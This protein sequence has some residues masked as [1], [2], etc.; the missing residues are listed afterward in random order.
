[1]VA[2]SDGPNFIDGFSS[3]QAVKRSKS[4]DQPPRTHQPEARLHALDEK[5][6]DEKPSGAPANR[7][8]SRSVIPEK[9]QITCYECQYAF[10]HTGRVVDTFCP[11]CHKKL[12]AGSITVDGKWFKDV[13]TIGRVEILAGAS[14]D[15][16]HITAREIALHAD[17]SRAVI[18]AHNRLELFSGAVF[19]TAETVIRTLVIPRNAEITLHESIV[20]DS[21]VVLGKVKADIKASSRVT[22]DRGGYF[23]GSIESPC[24]AVFE[25]AGLKA[26][27]KIGAERK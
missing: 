8:I 11:K 21:L 16:C 3:V 12:E 26:K 7:K 4:A 22:V 23:K 27:L 1:M 25:G 9:V 15:G 2:R 19:N 14:V 18:L 17:A 20:C 5:P 24:L 6:P 13:R 10:T